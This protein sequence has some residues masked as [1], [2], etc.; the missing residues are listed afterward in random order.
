MCSALCGE[1]QMFGRGKKEVTGQKGSMLDRMEKARRWRRIVGVCFPDGIAAF[2]TRWK[3]EPGRA[4]I[5]MMDGLKTKDMIGR[6]AEMV[7]AYWFELPKEDQQRL[8]S[9]MFENWLRLERALEKQGMS[10]EGLVSEDVQESEK[11]AL[12]I[13]RGS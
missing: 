13:L 9:M 12:S 3:V 6:T 1:E 7:E 10:A 8:A 11:K 4:F 2:E 5:L